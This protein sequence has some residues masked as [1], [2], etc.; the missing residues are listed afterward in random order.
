MSDDHLYRC[1]TIQNMNEIGVIYLDH[2]DKWGVALIDYPGMDDVGYGLVPKYDVTLLDISFPELRQWQEWAAELSQ[3]AWQHA[4]DI[5][6]YDIPAS[7]EAVN[8][9]FSNL[10]ETADWKGKLEHYR[11][12]FR[13]RVKVE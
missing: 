9:A 12:I 3:L 11:A 2:N 7:R 5:I 1:C 6:P 13:N 10:K 4:N 8:T